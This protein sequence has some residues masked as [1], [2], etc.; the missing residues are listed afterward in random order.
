[1]AREILV[2][3]SE[4]N[5]IGPKDKVRRLID[6]EFSEAR[7]FAKDGWRFVV[8]KSGNKYVVVTIERILTYGK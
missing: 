6:N 8:K 3:A 2:N 5:A 4:E 7:Y 1:M